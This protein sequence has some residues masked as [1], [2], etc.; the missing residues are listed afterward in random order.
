MVR[1]RATKALSRKNLWEALPRPVRTI[2]GAAL[3]RFP[4]SY[5]LGGRFR[6]YRALVRQAD[7]WSADETRNHQLEQCRRVCRLAYTQT[8]YYRRSFDEVGFNPRGM[9]SLGDLRLLPTIDKRVVRD[10]LGEMC[11]VA[12]GSPGVDFVST[13]GTGGEPLNFYIGADRSAVEYAHLVTSWERV[14]YQLGTPMAVIRGRLVSED[15]GG[16]RHEYD[17]LLRHHYYSNFH[18]TDVN[19]QQYL[20]HIAGL[21]PCYLHVYPSSV[22]ALARYI[23]RSGSPPP[24]NISGIIAESEFALSLLPTIFAKNWPASLWVI[25]TIWGF[26]LST[27]NNFSS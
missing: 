22:A 21:G 25:A 7:R 9:D 24:T 12:P 26:L 4:A 16:L 2:M 20:Q 10:H 23:R 14:G 6:R 17:P 27:V 15:R 11:T 1:G 8:T 3:G 5:L 18:M 13:G 19:M